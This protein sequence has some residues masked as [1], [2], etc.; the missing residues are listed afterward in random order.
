MHACIHTYIHTVNIY[1]TYIHTVRAL[2]HI[3][4]SL[5]NDVLKTVAC[6]IVSSRLDYCNAL[7]VGTSMSNL[8]LLQRVQN[9]LGR[10]IS[11]KSKLTPSVPLLKELHWLPVSHI[12]NF[13]L[14]VIAFKCLITNQPHYLVTFLPRYQPTRTLRSNSLNKNKTPY[15]KTSMAANKSFASATPH[16]GNSVSLEIATAP[17]L[18]SFKT[19]LK[20]H[21]FNVAHLS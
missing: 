10:L 18:Q 2:N 11:S 9:T 17:N 6:S 14:A 19:K 4:R 8:K 20:T 21:I 13:K 12:I 3:K 7:L 16:F 15:Y 5:P 1:C